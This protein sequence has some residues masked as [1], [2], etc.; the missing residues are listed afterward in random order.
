[1][2]N[3]GFTLL[4]MLVSLAIFGIIT[5]IVVFN[6]G[7]FNSNVLVTNLAY[8]I[9]LSIRQMQTYGL[10]VR[11]VD[12]SS[13]ADYAFGVHFSSADYQKF[14]LYADISKDGILNDVGSC[15]VSG[16]ECLE[17]I[18][19]RGDVGISS[20]TTCKT[21]T[22]SSCNSSDYVD[23][24]FLRPDPQAIIIENGE[25]KN[26]SQPNSLIYIN[27]PIE[28]RDNYRTIIEITG[29]RGAKKKNIVVERTGQISVQ[30]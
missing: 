24:L 7:A 21:E 3:K 19:L 23:I 17:E 14:Y 5:A 12:P 15:G 2:K 10:S 27:K 25:Y 9:A 13:S 30:D 18:N 16:S 26:G 11:N 22:S 4:E 8:E 28:K 29:Q 1:M 20:I 6:Y